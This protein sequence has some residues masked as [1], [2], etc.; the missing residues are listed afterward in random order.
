MLQ[1]MRQ[2][3]SLIGAADILGNPVGLVT[4]L[5]VGVKDFFYEPAAGLVTSPQE[6]PS[7][8]L[9]DHASQA[10]LLLQLKGQFKVDYQ[11]L[12]RELSNPQRVSWI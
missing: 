10:S 7:V 12:L 8:V 11:D 1:G 9:K 2:I 4:N 6:F 5:G 3:Y